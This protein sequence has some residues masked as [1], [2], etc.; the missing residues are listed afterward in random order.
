VTAWGPSAPAITFV[1]APRPK[2]TS[3]GPWVPSAAHYAAHV[4]RPLADSPAVE[5]TVGA[6]TVGIVESVLPGPRRRAGVEREAQVALASP[7]G[8]RAVIDAV[9]GV[10]LPSTPPG[11]RTFP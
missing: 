2:A 1:V 7:L 4:Q 11:I 5:E 8:E 10:E 9:S 3:R 6:V